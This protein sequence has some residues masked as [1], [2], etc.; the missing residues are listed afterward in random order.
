MRK[1]NQYV[2]WLE[3]KGSR[4]AVYQGVA[5]SE[6]EFISMC[7]ENGYDIH[8]EGLIIEMTH[9]NVKDEMGRPIRKGVSKD[10]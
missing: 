8:D 1:V 2:A 9:E 10:M 5:E 3:F 4:S 7:E 6:A